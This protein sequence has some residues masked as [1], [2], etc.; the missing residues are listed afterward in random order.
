MPERA[1]LLFD[2]DVARDFLPFTLTRPAGE[3]VFGACLQRRRAELTLG[4]H[5]LGHIA[6]AHLAAFEEPGAPPVRATMPPAGTLSAPPPGTTDGPL[7]YLSSRAVPAWGAAPLE[8]APAVLT[9]GGEPCGWLAPPGGV[10]PAGFL[11]DPASHAPAE[12]ACH[13]L[14]GRLLRR[15]WELVTLGE[16]QLE[17]DI[18][19]LAPATARPDLPGVYVLGDGHVSLGAGVRIEPQVV[20]DTRHGPIWLDDGVT[21]NAFTHIWGP[22]Y[23]GPRSTLL[24]EEIEGCSIGPVCRVHGQVECSFMLGYDN[25]AHTGFLGHAYIGRW[26]NLGALT[27][28]S[29]L[30]NNY[31]DVDIWTPGGI[32]ATGQTKLGC[33]IGDHVKTGIAL[34]LN[35]GTVMGAGCN[36]WGA[37]LPPK[38]VPPFSWGCG[39]RLVAYDL[40]KFLGMAA[41]A[42]A[43]RDVQLTESA[44]Q[45][46]RA[47]WQLGRAEA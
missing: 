37:E 35:T 3:L 15:V 1:L 45:Q 21:V 43:R 16:E 40:E 38:H 33:L 44:A 2:D 30:K 4:A 39:S 12:V 23:V 18:A 11:R 10:P 31:G 47:A 19:E 36:L 14:G 24:A 46:L 42:M 6:A 28:N 29:D 9:I 25:K 34:I 27:T 8:R 13:E 17:C 7:V 26:V 22:T 41:R 20:L 32:A 5:C